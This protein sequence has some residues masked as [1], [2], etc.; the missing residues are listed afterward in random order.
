MDGMGA[1]HLH[2]D[3]DMAYMINVSHLSL[4]LKDMLEANE[5]LQNLWVR[6]EVSNC[7]TYASGHCYFT[8]KEGEAQLPCVFFKYARLRSSAPELRD[9]MALAVNGRI[10]FYERDGKLQ[11]Y[12]ESV[13]SQGEGALFQRFEQLKQ[14]LAAEGLFDADRKRPL[15]DLP[16]VVGIVTSPQAAALRDMLRVLRTRYP[17]AQ[18]ILAPSLVQGADA[19]KSLA[20][21]IDLLNKHSAADVLILGRGGGSIEELWAFNEEIVARAIARSR[22]P[23]ISGI[24]HETDVTIAD[25]VADYRASTPTAAATMAVPA[26]AD[27]RAAVLEKRHLLTDQLRGR[28]FSLEEELEALKRE[29]QHASPLGMLERRQQ[30]LDAVSER[31][32]SHMSHTLSLQSERLRSFALQL[33]SLSPLLTIGRGYAIVRRNAD[34]AVVTSVQQVQA[35]DVVDIVVQ[36]GT[37][38]AEV[39]QEVKRSM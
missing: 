11:L 37:I 4:Y 8:L 39:R 14:R 12:V 22:I 6:G 16:T 32:Q 18:V 24:G 9:G 30:Q 23:V 2:D 17:L 27:W 1:L 38:T 5:I 35:G 19:P 7:K 10:S 33:H 36:D 31:L 13:K 34:Q 21:A 29:L 3:G 20:S 28:L 15:P 25:F 26:L